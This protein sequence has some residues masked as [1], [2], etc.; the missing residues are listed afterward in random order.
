MKMLKL[1]LRDMIDDLTESDGV[2]NIIEC[3]KGGFFPGKFPSED[4]SWMSNDLFT[5]SSA[6][7]HDIG[8]IW[9]LGGN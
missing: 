9:R 5:V 7:T 2:H 4:S 1:K 3:R 8:S 6:I